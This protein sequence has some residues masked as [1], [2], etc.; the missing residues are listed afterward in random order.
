MKI[1]PLMAMTALLVSQ[2]GLAPA[3]TVDDVVEKHLTAVG[4]REALGKLTSRTMSGSIT[5][6]TPG[7]DVT[8]TIEVYAKLP[9]KSRSVIDVDL[10]ALGA[11]RVHQDQ[12]FDGT[13]GYAIDSLNGNREITGDQL[14]VMRSAGF[15]TPL[16]K[17]KDA[18]AKVELMGKEK[19]G[20]QEAYVLRFTPRTGPAG[21]M[22]V[23]A[24]D[25]LLLKTV[26][27]IN[28]PQL[29]SSVEQ[30]VE[31]SDYRDVNGVKVAYTFR[32][33]NQ[34]QTFTITATKVEHNTEIDDKSFSK[35]AP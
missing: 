29:G 7:G 33:A 9:N 8:G 18:G 35:P 30:T 34:F 12:R 21:R 17:Y 1:W 26:I 2:A 3:Q 25:Y 5:L 24:E 27:T 10:S 16:L 20:A 4:G 6:S 19:V 22:F 15:P 23:G 28:V 14:E 32:S 11:G 31:F 13:T